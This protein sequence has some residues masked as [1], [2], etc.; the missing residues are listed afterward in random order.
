MSSGLGSIARSRDCRA[1]EQPWISPI[2]RILLI[3][4]SPV[5]AQTRFEVRVP[6]A[7]AFVRSPLVRTPVFG[8]PEVGRDH[9]ARWRKPRVSSVG[10]FF[11]S[12]SE[13]GIGERTVILSEHQA[14]R[15]AAPSGLGVVLPPPNLGL[16]PPGF[17]IPPL[18]GWEPD[19]GPRVSVNFPANLGLTPPGYTIPPLRGWERR[20]RPR[21]LG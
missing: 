3:V 16:T 10:L 21:V 6:T 18:R 2:A 12:P 1:I 20:P 4:V 14:V 15:G 9:K 11:Q 19:P 13:G 5:S 8:A 17:M 7:K